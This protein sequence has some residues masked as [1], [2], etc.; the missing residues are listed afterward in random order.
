MCP[1]RPVLQ[2]RAYRRLYLQLQRLYREKAEAD[3]AAVAGHVRSLL[4]AIGRAPDSI[5]PE[6]IRFYCKHARNLRL[7]R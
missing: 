7:V 1:P 4:Q 3:V 5:S 2:T 6:T